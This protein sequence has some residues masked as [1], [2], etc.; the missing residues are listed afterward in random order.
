[1]VETPRVEANGRTHSQLRAMELAIVDGPVP[2]IEPADEQRLRAADPELGPALPVCRGIGCADA[3]PCDNCIIRRR[4]LALLLHRERHGRVPHPAAQS[5]GDGHEP[6]AT[7]SDR[8]VVHLTDLGNARR[9]VHRHGENLRYCW[10][11]KKWLVWDSKRWRLDDAGTA[12]ALAKETMTAL[13]AE[14][15]DAVANIQKRLEAGDGSEDSPKVRLAEA[16][17]ILK[18][19]LKSESAPAISALLALARSE[20]R[21]A[22]RPA[23]L[24]TDHWLLNCTNGTLDLRT[25]ELKPHRREDNITK[26]C[27]V[28]YSPRA[29][30]PLFHQFL[31]DIFDENVQI[32]AYLHKLLGYCL[33]GDVSEQILPL[34]WGTG[35]NGKS[36]LL[37][38]ILAMLGADYGIKG[39]PDLLM[40]KRGES[41]PTERADLF[42]RRFVVCIE[43]EENRRLA[44]SLAKDLTGGDRQRARRMREDFWEYEPTHKIVICTNHKPII[45]G[46]DTAIW[47]RLRLVPFVVTIP[48]NRRDTKLLDKLKGE[49][50]GVLAWCVRGC[51]EWQRDGLGLPEEVK[52]ATAAYRTD[53]DILG[54]FVEERCFVN[55]E[56]RT[57]AAD[58][59]AAYCAWCKMGGETQ[60]TQRAFGT[61]MTER[62]FDRYQN[63]GTHYRG[64]AVR[65]GANGTNGT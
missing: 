31:R 9:L 50:P 44:E 25:A 59:Y 64:I 63:N 56:A 6:A 48:D 60:T 58:L 49:L 51:R 10:P 29:E 12:P 57:K 17:A 28:A 36:T 3:R 1:M 32:I 14:A 16:T 7:H 5:T 15:G 35:A 27:P 61:A 11:W 39:A 52:V 37:N 62:G 19:A 22:V 45:S 33:T 54:V 47:R 46:T 43:T 34:F 13:F 65:G 42:G 23:E 18:H 26:L 55:R 41:H 21:I 4:Y 38:V 8:E 53:Q 30:A 2:V 40:A 20:T 24:D